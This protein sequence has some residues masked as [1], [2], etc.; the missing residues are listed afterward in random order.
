MKTFIK[1]LK[2]I[3]LGFANMV[4]GFSGGTMAI[5]LNIYDEFVNAFA[6]IFKHPLKVIKNSWPI[7]VGLATGVVIALFTIIKL[8]DIAP[9]PTILFFIGIVISN[10]PVSYKKANF[11]QFKIRY[12]VIM[13]I[14][15]GIVVMMPL[16]TEN[17]LG[18]VPIT[19]WFLLLV[20]LMGTISASAM[21]LPGLSGSMLLM[22]FGFF[23]YIVKIID[24]AVNSLIAFDWG[25]F[26]VSMGVMG[27]F[28][29]GSVFG[30][31]A[32]SKLVRVFYTKC[33]NAFNVAVVGLLAASPVSILLA[34][35]KEYNGTLFNAP[36]WMYLIGIFTLVAG[37]VASYYAEKVQRNIV[38]LEDKEDK[39]NEVSEVSE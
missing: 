2:G 20:A 10:I 38:E 5:M 1:Y 33:P 12:L 21:V 34:T 9:L 23:T 32:V 11:E 6:D 39:K 37:V 36:W 35:N 8:L 15:F 30:F 14:M 18:D 16:L 7:F 17:S 13:A 25:N 31:V 19:F 22:A 24:S 3:A 28:L 26:G 29:L 4:P 27:M